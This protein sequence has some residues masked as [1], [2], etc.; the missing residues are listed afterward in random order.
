MPA[1]WPS[2]VSAKTLRP[3]P[4]GR[5]AMQGGMICSVRSDQH[6]AL[7]AV[8]DIAQDRRDFACR[9][10]RATRYCREAAVYAAVL[11]CTHGAAAGS[12]TTTIRLAPAF[13]APRIARSSTGRA[14]TRARSE[15][16]GI[17]WAIMMAVCPCSVRI[18]SVLDLAFCPPRRPGQHHR[19]D[20]AHCRP[21]Q[22]AH[23]TDQGQSQSGGSTH[24]H[25][26]AKSMFPPS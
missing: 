9:R 15:S 13:C 19:T 6:D 22:C 14:P 17:P 24:S 1:G 25:N 21:E 23:S 11:P 4:F 10:L 7:L 3:A 2:V 5:A 16:A 8:C 26:C 20:R 12:M 18:S